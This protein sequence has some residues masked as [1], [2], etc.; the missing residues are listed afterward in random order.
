[1]STKDIPL[2]YDMGASVETSTNATKADEAYHLLRRL[3]V[4]VQIPPGT[5]L[6]ER[7]IAAQLGVGRTPLREALARLAEQKLVIIHR[8]RNTQ[9]APLELSDVTHIHELRV[10]LECLAA[11]LAAQRATERDIEA[12]RGLL[13]QYE[14]AAL[15]EDYQAAVEIDY[16]FHDACA[17]ASHNPYLI[18]AINRLNSHSQRLWFISL[19][20]IGA[21]DQIVEKH[22]QIYEAIA[23]RDPEEAERLMREHID[24]FRERIRSLL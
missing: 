24:N 8:H 16:A 15:R 19:R 20:S 14:D 13:F 10:P 18:D 2:V 7:K 23:R 3:I 11:R 5:V 17:R 22:R 9:V 12:I 1:M 6:D 4:T 21:L